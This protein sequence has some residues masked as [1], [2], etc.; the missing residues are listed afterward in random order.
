MKSIIIL[1]SITF[2]NL[3]GQNVPMKSPTSDKYHDL[4]EK[5]IFLEVLKTYQNMSHYKKYYVFGWLRS[6]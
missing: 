5:S 3:L 1:L 6:K 4:L 2:L